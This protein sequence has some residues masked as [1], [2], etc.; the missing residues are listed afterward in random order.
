MG[1]EPHLGRSLNSSADSHPYLVGILGA[2]VLLMFIGTFVGFAFLA[3]SGSGSP[4]SPA[5]SSSLR[6]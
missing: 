4:S 3:G 5:S 1:G 2:A 6:P